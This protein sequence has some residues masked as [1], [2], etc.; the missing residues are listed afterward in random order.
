MAKVVDIFSVNCALHPG[1]E[2]LVNKK[3]ISVMKRGV[4][5]VN[6]ARGKICNEHDI[7]AGVK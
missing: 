1:T 5:I 6:T 7:A 4:Y 3:L 2:Y